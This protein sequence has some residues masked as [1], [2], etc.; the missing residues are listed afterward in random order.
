[1]SLIGL[2]IEDEGLKTIDISHE[3]IHEGRAFAFTCEKT[4][5]AKTVSYWMYFHTNSDKEVHFRASSLYSSASALKAEL[6][7]DVIYSVGTGTTSLVYNHNRN[8]NITTD[9]VVKQDAT[10]T[11]GVRLPATV[12]AGIGGDK[13]SRSGGE[14]SSENEWVL[15]PDSS[16]G[17]KITNIG[18]VD[19]YISIEP[20]WYEVSYI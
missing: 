2:P 9:V 15:K 20:F 18:D 16:Y 8:S 19:T 10:I 7:E 17:V 6:W 3:K 1:M 12:Y 13:T 4:D 5:L 14:G 11:G